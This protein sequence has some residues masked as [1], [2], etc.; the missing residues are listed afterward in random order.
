MK[1][2]LL[3]LA[4]LAAIHLQRSPSFEERRVALRLREVNKEKD[5]LVKNILLVRQDLNSRIS[6]IKGRDTRN[7]ESRKALEALRT[8]LEDENI[9]VHQIFDLNTTYDS[10]IRMKGASLG[11]LEEVKSEMK[12]ITG[13][14]T[15]SMNIRGDELTDSLQP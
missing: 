13:R 3:I 10:W 12:R 11:A 8:N 15:E 2:L 14:L 6:E 4:V 5:L 1:T 9:R 7:E